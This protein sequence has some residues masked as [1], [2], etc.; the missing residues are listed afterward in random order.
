VSNNGYAPLDIGTVAIAGTDASEFSK[1]VDGCSDTSVGALGSCE[2]QVAFEPTS[3]GAKAAL[4]SVPSNDP[5]T[6]ALDI[7]LSGEGI[8]CVYTIDPQSAS[9]G[10]A[11]GGGT[12]DVTATSVCSWTAESIVDTWISITSGSVGTGNGQVTYSVA[13]H[14]G[15]VPRIGTISIAGHDFTV[16]QGVRPDHIG[17]FRDGWWYLD[18]NGTPGWNAGD[19]S[20]KFGL[21]TDVPI[22]GDWDGDGTTNVGVYRDRWWYLDS[23]G[24][25]GWNAGDTSIKFG[26]PTDIPVAG[27]WNGNGTQDIGVYRD[28]WWYLDSNGTPGW[29]A[30]D[31]SVKF[32]KA[33]DVPVVGDWDG[34]GKTNIG[35]FRAGYWY[36]DSNGTL[37]WNAG[38]TSVKFGLYND[39]PVTGDWNDNGI[40]DIGVIRDRWWYLDT[41]GNLAWDGGVDTA[42]RFGFSKDKPV[43]GSW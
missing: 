6:A 39:I 12:V 13:E 34:D 26:V 38:D 15:S 3:E 36:L 16:N 35:V 30:G 43:T 10:Y 5:D 11:G 24:T 2:I 1:Q 9:F 27:D 22:V 8:L 19:T 37:G 4:I 14:T 32:G 18:S 7:P 28:G 29:N 20:V 31:T 33:G 42:V 17:V 40:T 25:P 23:N 21:A 41:N